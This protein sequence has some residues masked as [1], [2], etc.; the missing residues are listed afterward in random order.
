MLNIDG[1]E[2]VTIEALVVDRQL[3]G[4]DH[5][6]GIDAIRTAGGVAI[7][8]TGVVSFAKSNVCAEIKLDAPDFCAEFDQ[9]KNCCTAKWKW[10]G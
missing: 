9:T 8:P 7:T 1:T 10:S 2:L 5:I 3:L 6:F 4:F